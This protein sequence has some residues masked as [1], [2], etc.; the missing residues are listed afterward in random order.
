MIKLTILGTTG[1]LPNASH[2]PSCFGV[3][4]RGTYLFDACEGVQRQM[5]KYKISYGSIEFIFISHL[6]ADHWLGLPGLIQSINLN[7][8]K[9]ELKIF[10]PKGIKE[11]IEK[12][13]SIKWLKP[14]FEIKVKEIKSGKFFEN[15]LFECRAFEVEHGCPA[16]GAVF[17]EKEKIKFDE[18]K[19]K[20]L[21]IRGKLFREIEKKG[22]IK[23]GGKIIALE[24]IAKKV[25][26]KKIVYS[27]DTQKCRS[28]TE[29]AENAD[30]LICDSSFVEKDKELAEEKM[31]CTAKD[32]G[33]MAKKAKVKKLIL[34]HFSNRYADRKIILREAKEIFKNTE[35]AE[36]GKEILL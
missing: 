17:E 10:G 22:K 8:R 30:V 34:T 23:I 7:G 36:E 15:E 9:K 21:G 20:K 25:K 35:L 5:M 11:L 12:L 18:K 3:K 32:A 31:H 1:A 28:L 6:H 4:Y 19:A 27:G 2:L 13:L 14:A 24:E 33:E 26:G 16:L 29:N